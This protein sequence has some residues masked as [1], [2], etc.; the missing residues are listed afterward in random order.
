MS[1]GEPNKDSPA[2][3]EAEADGA[4]QDGPL[5][6]DGK[7]SSQDTVKGANHFDVLATTNRLI[8]EKILRDTGPTCNLSFTEA[9]LNKP[10]AR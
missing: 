1:R 9:E 3:E 5:S 10:F 7:G 6:S 4:K 8:A 2:R